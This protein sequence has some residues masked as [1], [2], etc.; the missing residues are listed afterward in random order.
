MVEREY[1]ADSHKE[2]PA[3]EENSRDDTLQMM[4]NRMIDE[5]CPHAAPYEAPIFTKPVDNNNSKVNLSGNA[6]ST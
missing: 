6:P 2:E 4:V 3:F 1:V 5:G